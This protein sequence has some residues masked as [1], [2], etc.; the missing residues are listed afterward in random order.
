LIFHRFNLDLL[1]KFPIPNYNPQIPIFYKVNYHDFHLISQN[2]FH[3]KWLLIN[4][5]LTLQFNLFI[6]LFQY[7]FNLFLYLSLLLPRFSKMLIFVN[8][9]NIITIIIV[10]FIPL[11]IIF[12]NRVLLFK[13]THRYS[14]YFNIHLFFMV[15]I[16]FTFHWF[17]M[18]P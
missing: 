13:F 14:N 15:F 8:A 17:Q 10:F 7:R 12:I 2:F 18:I 3:W 6:Y 11:S 4:R 5:Y 1:I 9:S 16:I